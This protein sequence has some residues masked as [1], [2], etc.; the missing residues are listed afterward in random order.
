MIAYLLD[1]FFIKKP[2]FRKFVTR[3]IYGDKQVLVDLF[4]AKFLLHTISENGYYR[5]SKIAAHSS[6]FRD[7][8]PVMIALSNLIENDVT[9]VDIGANVGIYSSLFSRF[10]NLYQK[11]EIAAF[12]VHPETFCRLKLNAEIYGFNA[13]NVGV[14]SRHETVQFVGGAVSHVTTRVDFANSYNI[15]STVFSAE[16]VPLSDFDFNNHLIIKIDVEGQELAVLEGAKIF[17][18]QGRVACVYLD[19]YGE[20]SCWEF[21]EHYGFYFLDGRTLMKAD[22]DTFALLAVK[23]KIGRLQ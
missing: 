5:A 4:G 2:K 11:F 14:G 6:L 3:T 9:F 19:G 22:R 10:K 18:E 17:F 12:E 15:S 23:Q 16:I 8:F 20:K 7:E 1:K 21:L 13:F